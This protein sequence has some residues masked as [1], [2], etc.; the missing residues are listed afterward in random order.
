LTIQSQ[1][2]LAAISSPQANLN[3]LIDEATALMSEGVNFGSR[4]SLKK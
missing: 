2:I 3:D 1:L 4:E